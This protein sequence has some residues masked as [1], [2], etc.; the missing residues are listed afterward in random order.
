MKKTDETTMTPPDEERKIS[1]VYEKGMC[2]K[3]YDQKSDL[4]EFEE[5]GLHCLKTPDGEIAWKTEY[6]GEKPEILEKL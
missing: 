6:A 3:E 5:N 4:Q 2:R 1:V